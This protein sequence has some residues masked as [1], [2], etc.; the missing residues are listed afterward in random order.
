[1]SERPRGPPDRAG[2]SGRRAGGY[3]L[4]VRSVEHVGIVLHTD[5]TAPSEKRA[6]QR[7][8][9]E[10]GVRHLSW[11]PIDRGRRATKAARRAV[12][13]GA[14]VV[15]ACGGDGTVRAASQALAG[16]GVPLAVLPT[17][18]ANLFVHGLD[19]PSSAAAVADAV[20]G[21]TRRCVD[22]A[23]CNGMAFNVMAGTGFDAALLDAAEPTKDRWGT[24]AYLRAGIAES[25][26]VAPFPLQV[27]V[28]DHLVHDGPATGVLV[29]NIGRL[30]AGIDALPDADPQDGQLDVA[31]ITAAGARAWMSLMSSAVLHRQRRSAHV[32]IARGTDVVVDL[33]GKRRFELDGGVKGKARRLEI[34]LRPSALVVCG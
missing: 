27:R 16:S 25:R 15:V 18:T 32:E 20:V 17:G 22:S 1:M 28:D 30:R 33:A 8:L 29:A 11:L 26:R 34:G 12:A 2:T 14:D 13:E 23:T 5:K 6:L 9:R 19:L 3:A 10:R 21:S 31:V 4:D 24:L 7:A